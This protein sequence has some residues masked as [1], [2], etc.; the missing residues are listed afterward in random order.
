[1]DAQGLKVRGDGGRGLLGGLTF[2]GDAD[3]ASIAGMRK[4]ASGALSA[5]WSAGQSGRG[6]P[7]G[8]DLDIKGASGFD[9]A[10][11]EGVAAE[12]ASEDV[13][14]DRLDVGVGQ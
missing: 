8:L 3:L 10:G 11:G 12:N 6:K 2:K 1:M 5:S 4:G 7:W 13:D 14:E 9:D